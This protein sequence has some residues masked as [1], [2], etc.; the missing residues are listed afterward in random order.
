M[1]KRIAYILYDICTLAIYF[2]FIV[3][4]NGPR[5]TDPTDENEETTENGTYII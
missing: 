3:T 4:G 5:P 1:L 2:F